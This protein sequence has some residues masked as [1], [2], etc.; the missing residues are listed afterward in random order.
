ML[1]P[2]PLCNWQTMRQGDRTTCECCGRSWRTKLAPPSRGY[3]TPKGPPARPLTRE[4]RLRK[5]NVNNHNLMLSRL[6][7]KLNNQAPWRISEDRGTE[8]D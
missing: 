6:I 7:S 8:W 3:R 1:P 2:N 5:V 4:E